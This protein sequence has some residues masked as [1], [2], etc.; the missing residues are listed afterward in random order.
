MKPE[1]AEL[2]RKILALVDQGHTAR[3][4]AVILSINV[5]VVHMRLKRRKHAAL[6]DYLFTRTNR[7]A[8]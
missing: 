5:D 4:C 3:E 8:A 1:S 7:Q 2:T 6:I